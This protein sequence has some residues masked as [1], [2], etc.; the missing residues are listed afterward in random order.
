VERARQ[1]DPLRQ[2]RFFCE[3]HG[4]YISP[5][6][7]EYEDEWANSLWQDE[8]DRQ[9]RG[10]IKAVKRESRFARDNSEDA[11]TWNVFRYLEKSGRLAEFL[12]SVIEQP[13]ANAVPAY[14]SYSSAAN[15]VSPSL[16]L[17]RAEFG[18]AVARSTEP[19]LIIESDG[20]LIWIESKL[21]ATNDTVPTNP[22]DT[23][24]YLSG[25]ER[26]F[27]KAFTGDYQGVA[28]T[29]G[30]YELMRLWLLGSWAA[31]RE[32]RQFYLVNLV[33]ERAHET[34]FASHIAQMPG[35][36][37]VCTTWE[38]FYRWLESCPSTADGDRVI[39][40]LRQKSAGYANGAL[41]TA[42]PT[43]AAL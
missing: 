12:T 17:A 41:K 26:W 28:I 8:S 20:T 21:G 39:Q 18:E 34:A 10:V 30:R 25:G 6:T 3:Q 31:V 23:K 9:L 11:L 37:F 33:S 7:F 29:A 43:L 14:W 16:A 5:S 22:Q 1:G 38:N 15:G 19:D 42:F 4:I 32:K 40:Y 13:V 24:G 35:A 36:I 2:P 27:E